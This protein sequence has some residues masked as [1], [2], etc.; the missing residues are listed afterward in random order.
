MNIDDL[1]T[2]KGEWL[3]GTGPKSNIVVSSRVRLA[4]NFDGFPFYNRANSS[5]REKILNTALD[6]LKK[7]RYLK[8]AIFLKMDDMSE[9]DRQFLVER[10]LMSPEHMMNPEA[11]ALVIDDSEIASIM[12]NDEDHLRIQILQSGFNLMEA[13]RIIDELDNDISGNTVFAF[14]E[15]WGYLTACPTNTG[16]G[17]R[18]SVMLHLPALVVTAQMGKVI[19]AIS[20]LGLTIRGLYGEG[21]EAT[22]DFFQISNQVSLG[23]SEADLLDNIERIVNKIIARE[24]ATRSMLLTKNKEKIN[25]RISRAYGTLINAKIITSQEAIMLLS[26]IRLGLDLG[27]IKNVGMESVNELFMLTQPAHLQ[28]LEGK[29]LSAHQRDSKRAELV[30]ER[31]K[32]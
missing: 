8:K 19:Q 32:K 24:S 13:W 9:I 16:T 20:K 17:L 5:V 3:K 6:V 25:D 29:I 10:H 2:K 31:L 22:G 7:A 21:T 26:Q 18:G 1:L 4:R 30:K 14:S 12:I 28:K 27:I 11:K 23:H 15:R